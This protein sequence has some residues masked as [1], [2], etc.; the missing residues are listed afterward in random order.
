MIKNATRATFDH[1]C[2]IC[3][4]YRPALQEESSY[5]IIRCHRYYAHRLGCTYF[6][7]DPA[8]PRVP[9]HDTY[10]SRVLPKDAF[11]YVVHA[12][13]LALFGLF[14]AH[15]QVRESFTVK[16]I[17]GSQPDAS[18]VLGSISIAEFMQ[19]FATTK[20]FP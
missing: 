8:A 3:T 11:V 1:V 5:F 10:R 18:T 14:F 15:V 2:L 20:F 13:A 19:L 6:N 7:L 9:A 4:S 12:V 16:L 17:Q